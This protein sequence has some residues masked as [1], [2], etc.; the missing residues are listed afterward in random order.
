MANI[1]ENPSVPTAAAQRRVMNPAPPPRRALFVYLG[2]GF[3]ICRSRGAALAA[4]VG[5]GAEVEAT[6]GAEALASGA[7]VFLIAADAERRP[8]Q[9]ED[10]GQQGEQ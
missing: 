10:G 8:H 9:G 6:G 2:R 4:A 7:A 1:M 5:R 3:W